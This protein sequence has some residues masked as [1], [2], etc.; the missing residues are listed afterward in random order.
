MFESFDPP[1]LSALGEAPE[2][3]VA[4]GG[5]STLLLDWVLRVH[6]ATHELISRAGDDPPLTLYKGTLQDAFSIDRSIIGS[7]RIGEDVTIGLGEVTVSNV[8]G[9]YDDLAS[10]SSPLGQEIEIRMGDRRRP[11]SEWRVILKGYTVDMNMDRDQVRFSLRDSGHRLD[12]PASP[13][14]YAGTGGTEGGEDLKGKRKPRV[15][16]HAP[17]VSAPLVIA[18][19]LA[20][21][22]NDG[23]MHAVTAA[24]VRG[25]ALTPTSDH[26]SVAAMNAASLSAG[27][28]ATCLSAG[29]AR[30][31]VASGAET[32]QVTWDVQGDATDGAFAETTGAIVRRLLTTAGG[33]SDPGDLVPVAFDRLDAVQPAPVGYVIPAGDDQTVRDAVGRLMAAIGGWCGANRRGRFEA[34]RFEAPAGVPT[35]VYDKRVITDAQRVAL[36]GDVSPPPWRVRVGWGR[37]NT[38]QTTDLAGAVTEARRAYLAAEIRYAAAQDNNIRLTFPP[39]AEMVVDGYFRDESAAATE[40]AR[41]LALFGEPRELYAVTLAERLYIHEP[42]EVVR[43]EFDRYGLDAGRLCTV[44]RVRESRSDGGSGDGV[45]LTVFA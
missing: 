32:G 24:Y 2:M 40:A 23:P 3:R 5:T 18:S 25:V 28:Y 10:N 38:V 6:A 16:G 4:F 36:P 21:Q 31:A 19:S 26:A 22:L 17:N 39:G 13:N 35:G 45:E 20:Y 12:V 9:D 7:A 43:V 27:K 33:L 29:W 34:R 37:N 30:I 44:V 41:R 15:F 1:G 42:G 11:L 8:E 14:V